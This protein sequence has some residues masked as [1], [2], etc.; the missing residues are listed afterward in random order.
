MDAYARKQVTALN[1]ALD[2]RDVDAVMRLTGSDRFHAEFMIAV[3]HG[4]I[5]GCLPLEHEP[6]RPRTTEAKA[7]R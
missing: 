2:A 6:H 1:A 7:T 3:G 5:E 4:D